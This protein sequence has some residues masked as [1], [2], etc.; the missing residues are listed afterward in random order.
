MC[1]CEICHTICDHFEVGCSEFE[2]FMQVVLK[3]FNEISDFR[4]KIKEGFDW[5]MDFLEEVYQKM[6]PSFLA[7]DA[8]RKD[9][10]FCSTKIIIMENIMKMAIKNCQVSNRYNKVDKRKLVEDI[11]CIL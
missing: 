10:L 2:E 11:I 6:W 3:I 4:E 7:K 8:S 5:Y 9:W 1:G